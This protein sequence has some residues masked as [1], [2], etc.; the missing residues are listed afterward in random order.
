MILICLMKV[1]LPLSP[2]PETQHRTSEL[3]AEQRQNMKKATRTSL[4]K[5]TIAVYMGCWIFTKYMK[6][7]YADLLLTK[8][9]S[10]Q[11]AP[12]LQYSGEEML[13]ASYVSSDLRKLI[14]ILK[15]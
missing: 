7:V 8:S 3:E 11:N 1:L 2:V 9:D 10:V 15:F 14:W 5:T 4:D 6:Y 13:L 12:E